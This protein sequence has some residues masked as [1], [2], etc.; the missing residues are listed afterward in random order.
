MPWDRSNRLAPSLILHD[1]TLALL[2]REV[3]VLVEGRLDREMPS[4][5]LLVP[6]TASLQVLRLV[7]PKIER[8]VRTVIGTIVEV[9]LAMIER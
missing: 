2:A 9:G 8:F 4:K 7:E 5:V 1:E 3:V 6:R